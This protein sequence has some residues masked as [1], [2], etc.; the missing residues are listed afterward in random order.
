MNTPSW[1]GEGNDD[2]APFCRGDVIRVSDV[3]ESAVVENCRWNGTRW[4]VT[5][6]T[7]DMKD[8]SEWDAKACAIIEQ[9]PPESIEDIKEAAHA[10]A[11]NPLDGITLYPRGVIFDE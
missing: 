11:R 6:P 5:I 9:K 2:G 8:I 3:V 10:P 7:E 1:L 4:I